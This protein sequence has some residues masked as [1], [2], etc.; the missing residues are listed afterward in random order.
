MTYDLPEELH[1]FPDVDP[2]LVL[3]IRLHDPVDGAHLLVAKSC[4]GPSP[5]LSNIVSMLVMDSFLSY[6]GMFSFC[7]NV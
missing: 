1:Q 2:Q 7:T 5:H 4:E 6:A 3:A